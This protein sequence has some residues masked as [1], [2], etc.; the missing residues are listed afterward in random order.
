MDGV[1]RD[2]CSMKNPCAASESAEAKKS[3]K[4]LTPTRK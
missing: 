4:H 2:V 3:K 1:A